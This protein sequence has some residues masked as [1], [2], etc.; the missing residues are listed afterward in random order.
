MTLRIPSFLQK[1]TEAAKITLHGLMLP[2]GL[3]TEVKEGSLVKVERPS[4]D[5]AVTK[6][7][8]EAFAQRNAVKARIDRHGE[9]KAKR[10]EE[11]RK[12]Q[13]FLKD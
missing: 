8:A 11:E 12:R 13:V 4:F 6:E 2:K 7:A 10:L 9:D 3:K 5:F 1:K